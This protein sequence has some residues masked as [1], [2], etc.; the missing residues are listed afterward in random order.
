MGRYVFRRLVQSVFVVWGTLTLVFFVLRLVGDPVRLMAP[1][2]TTLE[3]LIHLRHVL[4]LDKPLHLQ[5]LLF[6]RDAASG[7][8]GRSFVF[9]RPAMEVIMEFLPHTLLL[10][11]AATVVSVPMAL[12][13]GIVSAAKP[14][15]IF[16]NVATLVAVVGRSIPHFW[17]GLMLIIAFSVRL[18]WLPPSGYGGIDN[19]IMP[20]LT[21]GAAVAGSVAR[22]TRSSML[23]VLHADY[24]RTARAKGLSETAILVGH[25][26]RSALIPVVTMIGLQVAE[27]LGGAITVELVFSWPGIGWLLIASLDAYD[28][29]MIQAVICIICVAFVFS[30]L[31][32]DVLY[33]YLD[34]RIRYL[35]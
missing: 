22:L 15:S 4:G 30:N 32:V 17:L 19:L 8:F 7:N 5:Y 27:L 18:R 26:L 16:D 29:P 20:A 12:I 34:P 33:T 1:K 13:L 14:S 28:Y 24:I 9:Q 11:L 6:L 3:T 10:S 31:A 2:Y 23:E 25:A 21:L 35:E